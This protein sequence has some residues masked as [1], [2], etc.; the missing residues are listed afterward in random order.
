[1]STKLARGHKNQ[2]H[3]ML[4]ERTQYEQRMKAQHG[5][6]V[7]P[8]SERARKRYEAQALWAVLEWVKKQ[9]CAPCATR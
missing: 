7:V 2:L 5:E 9:E 8:G 6:H 3:R 4:Q 1:M